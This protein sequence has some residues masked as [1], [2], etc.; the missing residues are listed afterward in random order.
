MHSSCFALALIK[1]CFVFHQRVGTEVWW[2][3]P[4]F[5]PLPFSVGKPV[6]AKRQSLPDHY[7][8]AKT[9]G[10]EKAAESRSLK[11]LPPCWLHLPNQLSFPS[12]DLDAKKQ[13][14][15]AAWL[16]SREQNF[17][18]D[19]EGMAWKMA[20]DTEMY[21]RVDNADP[22]SAGVCESE[23]GGSDSGI[24]HWVMPMIRKWDNKN[25]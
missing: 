13:W 20:L 6:G 19:T 21:P 18:L 16:K 9:T 17:K 5:C 2:T 7:L 14:G 12:Q 3:Y 23:D 4:L 8:G 22:R 15:S 11:F 10:E 25:P 24:L 1:M